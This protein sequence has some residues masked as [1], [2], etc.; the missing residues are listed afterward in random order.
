MCIL[1]AS[2][3]FTSGCQTKTGQFLSDCFIGPSPGEEA[4]TKAVMDD[5]QKNRQKHDEMFAEMERDHQERLQKL[6]EDFAP[7][8]NA[9]AEYKTWYKS[10]NVS[11]QRAVDS[12][13]EQKMTHRRIM[14]G[15]NGVD[16]YE[17]WDDKFEIMAE[18]KEF[19]SH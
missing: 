4:Y 6:N 9:V 17:A 15:P 8:E 1:F 16:V 10:L 2:L 19:F 11:E 13:L 5:F 12:A 7:F 3:G 14:Q 18:Y